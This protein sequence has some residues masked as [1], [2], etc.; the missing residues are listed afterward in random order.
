MNSALYE[1][2]V[3]HCRRAPV[4]HEFQYRL[5]LMYLD[6]DEL[7]D[8]F[9]DRW[10]W[11][12]ERR[13]VAQFRRRDHLG[14]P[15]V[16][17]KTAVCDLVQSLGHPRPEGPIRLLTHLRYFGYVLNPVSFFF[18]FD[19][20]GHRVELVV[21]EVT[22]TPW[23]ERHCYLLVP[24][25]AGEGDG[26]SILRCRHAKEFHVSPFMGMDMEYQWQ[27]EPPGES[28]SVR[29][30]NCRG[31]EAVFDADLQLQRR[32]LNTVNLTRALVRFPWMTARIAAA[33]Y[34]QALRLW[35]KRV[36]FVPHPRTRISREALVP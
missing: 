29:I 14:D 5:F 28:L 30:V 7:D 6:L 12:N 24:E 1:G 17:L 19:R 31:G 36:P 34:W 18:C 27:I 26:L 23:G 15:A 20:D 11:S 16:P 25:S 4:R 8:V 33:I 10:L 9:A 32:E 13:S 35:W 22:N 21:A 3:R 2:K